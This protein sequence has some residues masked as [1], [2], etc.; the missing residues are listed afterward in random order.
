MAC[1]RRFLISRAK[2]GPNP[3][4]PEQNAF[5]ADIDPTLVQQVLDISERKREPDIHQHGQVDDLG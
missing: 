3:I 5:V 4:D 1:D 2:I